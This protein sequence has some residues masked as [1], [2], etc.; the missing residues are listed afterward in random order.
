VGRL[1]RLPRAPYA[2]KLGTLPKDPVMP[3]EIGLPEL[4]ARGSRWPP[5]PAW[6]TGSQP[7]WLMFWAHTPV[8]RGPTGVLWGYQIPPFGSASVTGFVPDFLE[9]DLRISFDVNDP[10][11]GGIGQARATYT[12]RKTIMES[13]AYTHLLCDASAAYRNPITSLRTL[14]TGNDVSVL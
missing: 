13:F 8:G 14:L 11:R 6:W 10:M 9:M 3:E 4:P 12:L 7:E 5:H 2:P 1:P